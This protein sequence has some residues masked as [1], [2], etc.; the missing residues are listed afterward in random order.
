MPCIL[1]IFSVLSEGSTRQDAG[2]ASADGL[3]ISAEKGGES[4]IC[5]GKGICIRADAS[6]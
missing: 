2:N 3:G 1:H 6:A 4:S 5:R